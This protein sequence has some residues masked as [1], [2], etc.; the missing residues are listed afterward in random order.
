M[1]SNYNN[2]IY[3]W[4]IILI[5]VFLTGLSVGNVEFS[6]LRYDRVHLIDAYGKNYLFRTN[7]PENGI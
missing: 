2:P 4:L 7:S 6:Q 1:G 3:R 5:W